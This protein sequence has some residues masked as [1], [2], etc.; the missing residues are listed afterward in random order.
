MEILIQNYLTSFPTFILLLIM[1]AT[2][3]TLSKGADILVDQAVKLSIYLGVPKMIIGATIVSLGTT[4]PEASVSV[5]AAINDNPDLALGNAIG[6][7]IADTGL[8]IGLAALL[9]RLPVDRL[10][11]QRQGKI[12]VWAGI[13]LAFVSLPFFSGNHGN[14]SQPVGWLFILLLILYIYLSI[15]WTRD[16]GSGKNNRDNNDSQENNPLILQII[17]LIIGIAW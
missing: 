4:L 14:I 3:Y 12:Q 13:L 10:V 8:I 16:T 9:G 2:L 15:K 1:A 11:V 7:I 17:Q 5:L 6:S